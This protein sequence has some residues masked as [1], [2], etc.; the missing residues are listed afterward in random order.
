V[1]ETSL[2]LTFRWLFRV[3][4]REPREGSGDGLWICGRCSSTETTLVTHCPCLLGA[5]C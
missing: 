5:I 3:Q 4:R 2:G 1:S